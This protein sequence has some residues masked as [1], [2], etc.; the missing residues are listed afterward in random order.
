VATVFG[1]PS[2]RTVPITAGLGLASTS[3]RCRGSGGLGMAMDYPAGVRGSPAPSRPLAPVKVDAFP[4][5]GGAARE[6][7]RPAPPASR[8][9]GLQQRRHRAADDDLGAEHL[10]ALDVEIAELPANELERPLV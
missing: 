8:V 4:G 5:G 10:C 9:R 7:R 1:V 3:R 6:A 2:G